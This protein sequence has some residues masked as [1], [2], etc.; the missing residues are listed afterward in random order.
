MPLSTCARFAL[1]AGAIATLATVPSCVGSPKASPP[2]IGSTSATAAPT[3]TAEPS[4]SATATATPKATA[5]SKGGGGSGGTVSR[6]E[7]KGAQAAAAITVA[8]AFVAGDN[9][10]TKT[11]SYK[12]RDKVTASACEWCAQKRAYVRKIYGGGGHITG[13]LFTKN[14]YRVAGPSNGQYT[15]AVDTTVSKYREVDGSG[16]VID[17]HGPR[18]GVLILHVESGGDKVVAGAWQP[19]S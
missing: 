16:D 9:I 7:A 12:V 13:E 1:M 5:S 15:V 8:K 3:A 2:A 10:A 11:G 14:S 17:T 19:S 6:G 4:E 18:D